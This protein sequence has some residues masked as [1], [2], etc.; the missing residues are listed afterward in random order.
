[1]AVARS[2]TSTKQPIFQALFDLEW[3]AGLE[4]KKGKEEY[5]GI[6][7]IYSGALAREAR[8]GAPWVKKCGKLPILE[9]LVI[10]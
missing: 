1:M 9:N 6:H 3:P 7:L 10:T 8:S 5:N 4:E 2:K